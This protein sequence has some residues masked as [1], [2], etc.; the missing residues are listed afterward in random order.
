[1]KLLLIF[2]VFILLTVFPLLLACSST[3][4]P[5]PPLEL[6]VSTNIQANNGDLFYVVAKTT[7]EKAFMLDS[8]EDIANLAFSDSPGPDR[9][10]VFSVVPGT[11]Q[12]YTITQP[13]QGMIGLYFLLTKPG[14]QWKKLLTIP[15]EESYDVVLDATGKIVISKA[16]HWYSLF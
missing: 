2:K 9:L 3:P 7:S 16:K 10:G 4:E 15:F 6:N 13:A 5:P 8:Y 11:N 14:S 12:D 1:M